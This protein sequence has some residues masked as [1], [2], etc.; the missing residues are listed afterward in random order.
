MT[1]LGGGGPLVVMATGCFCLFY[2]VV[3]NARR[4]SLYVHRRP[5]TYKTYS[6]PE[7]VIIT[8]H[9]MQGNLATCYTYS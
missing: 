4:R 2:L 9:L 1:R 3:D 5:H 8:T 6:G 7:P